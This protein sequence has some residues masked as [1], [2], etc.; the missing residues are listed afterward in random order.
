MLWFSFI[1]GLNSTK[2]ELEPQHIYRIYHFERE[3][4]LTVV[5]WFVSQRPII[6]VCQLES[7]TPVRA[8]HAAQVEG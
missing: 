6:E 3:H 8:T 4:H 7:S 5:E 2:D 1:L